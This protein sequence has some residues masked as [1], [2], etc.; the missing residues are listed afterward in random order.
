MLTLLN[1][2]NYYFGKP[3]P[4]Y[5][6]IL[7]TIAVY[8]YIVSNYWDDIINNKLYLIINII[9]LLI[10]ITAI[11]MIFTVYHDNYENDTNL[12]N[13]N[14]KKNKKKKHIKNIISNDTKSNNIK[15]TLNIIENKPN[16]EK[17]ILSLYE[18][19]KDV[20]LNTYNNKIL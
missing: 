10:D 13:D 1:I 16:I 3:L 11:I 18:P 9:L 20:S 7:V 19:E 5:I 15:D 17:S 12:I 14:V 6:L 2:I 8:Y 4:F